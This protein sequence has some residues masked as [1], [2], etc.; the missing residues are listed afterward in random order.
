MGIEV[1]IVASIRQCKV[2]VPP[3]SLNCTQLAE[4]VKAVQMGKTNRAPSWDGIGWREVGVP[5][6]VHWEATGVRSP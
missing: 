3:S 5:V 2:S 1:T 4:I 6:R